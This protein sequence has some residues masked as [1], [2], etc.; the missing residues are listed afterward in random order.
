ML[1]IA[2]HIDYQSLNTPSIMKKTDLL[3]AV[4]GCVTPLSW[5]KNPNA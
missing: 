2:E 4:N 5:T 3:A 1:E